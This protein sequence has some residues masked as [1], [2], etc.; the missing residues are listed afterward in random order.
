MSH[1]YPRGFHRVSRR[2]LLQGAA[3]AAAWGP[4]A[5]SAAAEERP[6]GGPLRGRIQQAARPGVF[7]RL[8]IEAM[9]EVSVRLG[10][11]GL[12]VGPNDWATLKKYGLVCTIAGSHN[13]TKGLNRKENHGE[14]L[15]IIR[16]SIENAADAGWRNVICFSGN[17]AGLDDETGAANCAEGLKQ[18]AGLA[19]KKKITL[20]MELL[21]SKHDHKD[22]QCDHTAWG[23]AVCKKVGSPRVKLLYDIYHM[24][25]QEGDVIATIRENIEYIGH[26]HTAGVPGRHEIDETQELNY[27]AIMRAIADLKYE[28]YVAH[29]YTPRGEPLA[30]LTKA[31]AIC[32]V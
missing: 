1:A 5:L 21:N 23:V 31:V 3:A 15:A 4:A 14:C 22:Y 27:P 13:L 19:E 24:Q 2:R 17:R 9:C 28:G 30:S 8:S 25:I 7:G 32:D 10:L 20:C 11:K 12:E 26:F 6:S 16:K 18:I 29:E